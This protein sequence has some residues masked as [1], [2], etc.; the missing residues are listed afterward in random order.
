MALYVSVNKTNNLDVLTLLQ[1]LTLSLQN[2][3]LVEFTVH[4]PKTRLQSKFKGTVD[5]CLF[6]TVIRAANLCSLFQKCS[7]DI[8]ISE[9]EVCA[10]FCTRMDFTKMFVM[11]LDFAEF[12]NIENMFMGMTYRTH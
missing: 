3:T 9:M 4:C 7:G 5:S 6:L 11:S 12:K 1:G 8:I 10:I 2:A